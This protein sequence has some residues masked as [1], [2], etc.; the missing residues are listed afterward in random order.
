M[1]HPRIDAQLH[2]GAAL[3]QVLG[4]GDALVMQRVALR[5]QQQRRRQVSRHHAE[6][7][8]ETRVLTVLGATLV[9]LVEPLQAVLLQQVA[10]GVTLDRLARAA[11]IGDRVD[12]YLQTRLR[13]VSPQRQAMRQHR[14]QTAA[15]AV[16]GN[17]QALRIDA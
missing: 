9:V 12:Q 16:A 10:N 14:A 5:D 8:R 17:R 2:P 4:I 7:R 1:G 3:A 15:D 13:G 11:G 6:Q